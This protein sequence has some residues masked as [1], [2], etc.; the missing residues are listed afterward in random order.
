[1]LISNIL[2]FIKYKKVY[3]LKKKDINFNYITS[4]SK[5]IRKNSLLLVDF[6]SILKVVRG[7]VKK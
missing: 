5:L 1:M 3:N 6:K 7:K 4:N 2:N